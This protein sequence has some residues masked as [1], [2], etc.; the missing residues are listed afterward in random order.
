MQTTLSSLIQGRPRPHSHCHTV[1]RETHGLPS[2]PCL[3]MAGTRLPPC[4]LALARAVQAPCHS[5]TDCDAPALSLP[6]L[7]PVVHRQLKLR[8][9]VKA[10]RQPP[11]AAGRLARA[12]RSH[13]PS[14]R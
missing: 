7:P 2:G 1:T 11:A 5:L 10:N 3:L 12:G 9:R 13:R 8:R 6:T 14:S 4:S